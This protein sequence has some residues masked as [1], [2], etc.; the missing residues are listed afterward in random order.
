MAIKSTPPEPDLPNI[1]KPLRTS[2]LWRVFGWGG[3]ATIALAAVALT[4]Q[5]EAGGKRLQLAFAF[6]SDPTQVAAQIP[7][8]PAETAAEAETKRLAAQLRDLTADRV[9]LTARIAMLERNLEDM[10]G[11]IKQ[12]SEQ[13]AAARA[14]AATPPPAPS[15]PATTPAVVAAA[16]PPAAA[17]PALT[18]LAMPAA[19]EAPASWPAAT[20]TPEGEQPAA[21]PEAPQ[22]ATEPVPLPPVRVANA[23]AH[24]PV[25]EPRPPARDGFGVD[26]GGASSLEALRVHWAALKANYG[27]L[28]VGLQ[29]L[30]TQHPKRPSGT[31]YRLVVGPLPNAAEAVRLCARFPALRTGCHPAKFSGAQLAAR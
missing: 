12:Q 26:L 11:S 24:E 16:P 1:R 28:L 6:G 22:A 31:M 30:A 10:T 14:A 21:Q 2:P 7:P 29:A 8:R 27:P 9:R 3:A 19:G 13:L 4:S 5:T 23:P 17:L 20:T 25:A 15:A 18:P